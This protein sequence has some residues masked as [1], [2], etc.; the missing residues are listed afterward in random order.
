MTALQRLRLSALS[1]RMPQS[2]AMLDTSS[3]PSRL[4]SLRFVSPAQQLTSSKTQTGLP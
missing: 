4:S 2:D 1:L 3:Q